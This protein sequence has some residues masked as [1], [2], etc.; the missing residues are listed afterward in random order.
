MERPLY[1][2]S[3]GSIILGPS[4]RTFAWDFSVDHEGNEMWHD[5]EEA[6]VTWLQKLAKCAVASR[7]ALK[8]IKIEFRPSHW[9]NI[10]TEWTI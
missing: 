8:K 1:F 10:E 9:G 5:F 6:E 2:L 3:E 4:L 7:A